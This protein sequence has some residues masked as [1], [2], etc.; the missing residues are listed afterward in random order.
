M[1]DEELAAIE[2]RCQAA[3]DCEEWGRPESPL[4]WTPECRDE[5][6]QYHQAAVW[7]DDGD[8]CAFVDNNMG[9]GYSGDAIAEF[10]AGCWL[11]VPALLAEVRRLRAEVS[12]YEQANEDR[13]HDAAWS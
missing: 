4:T 3:K 12:E 7:F 11:D 6:G 9:L 5:N 8:S 2:R 10:F 13:G 1:T